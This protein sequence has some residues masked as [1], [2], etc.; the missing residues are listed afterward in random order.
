MNASSG[1][2]VDAAR[3]ESNWRAITAELDAPR[4]GRVERWLRRFGVPADVTR[5]VAATPALRRAW[6]ISLGVAVVVGLG[7]AEPNDRDSLFALLILAPALPVLGVSL[8]YGP[9]A[10]PMYEAQLATP[11]RGIRLVVVR[12]ITVLTVSIAILLPLTLLTP[13]ARGVAAL[14]LLPA[15]GLTM[16]ALALMTV[17]PPRRAAVVVGAAWFVFVVFVGAVTDE[18][19]AAFGAGGQLLSLCLAVAGGVVLALRR[20][21]F[22]RDHGELV[23]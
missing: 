23:T 19:L 18:Q 8:A 21:H 17:L 15:L 1:P 20:D 5:L 11:M 14:W 16:S 13:D 6:F 10:D 22:D 12:A 4:P 7:A 2:H 9:S 3:I